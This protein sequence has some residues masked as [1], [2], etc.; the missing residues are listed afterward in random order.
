MAGMEALG[1]LFN[2]VPAAADGTWVNASYASGIT[3]ICTGANAETF[4][5]TQA[6]TAAGAGSK[7]LVAV[8]HVFTNAG[9]AGAT[10]W[11]EAATPN[12]ASPSAV[13]T[14]TTAAPVAAFFVNPSAMD[15]GFKYVKVISSSTGTVIA[16]THDLVTGR[17]PSNL[18]ALGV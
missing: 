5:V 17:K 3:F 12:E 4:T 13:V 7:N 14:T 6:T 2:V 8:D 16:I 11:A 15:D 18:P 10:A 9:A 1:R